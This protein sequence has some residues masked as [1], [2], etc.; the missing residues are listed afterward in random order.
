MKP[1][2]I[3]TDVT[4]CTGCEACVGACKKEY[5][6]GPDRPWRQKGAIDDLSSTRH[7]TILSRP[8]GRY[9]RKQCRHC[10]QAAC[11]SACLVGAMQ[12]TPDGPVIYDEKKCMG[13][14]YCMVA[15]PYSIPR[16]DW[17]KAVPY[18]H[19]CTM[20]YTRIK[21]GK[22]PAC[23]EACPEEATIFGPRDEILALARQ[24]LKTEPQKYLQE[25][26]GEKE[27]GGTS[28][29][30]ISDIPLDFLACKPALGETPLPERTYAAL[31]K[32]PGI[33]LAMGGLLTGIY[34]IIGR[35]MRMQELKATAAAETQTEKAKTADGEKE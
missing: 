6:L 8:G 14:R 5:H 2:A 9:V 4:R 30:Y 17:N 15:C 18:V 27:V 22:Q 19:K 33:V 25:I 1:V 3:L 24:R 16:Y 7:T 35:R 11:V 20:C 29:L 21:T 31:S 26:Y 28:V 13:C 23:I 34:W 10:N 12:K 32:V